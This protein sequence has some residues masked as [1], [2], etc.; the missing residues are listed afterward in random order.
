MVL[1]D[2]SNTLASLPKVLSDALSVQAEVDIAIA[3]SKDIAMHI[4]GD[5][6]HFLASQPEAIR[7]GMKL[8]CMS[9][10]YGSNCKSTEVHPFKTANKNA[11]YFL[12]LLFSPVDSHRGCTMNIGF[13]PCGTH[14]RAT[15]MNHDKAVQAYYSEDLFNTNTVDLSARDLAVCARYLLQGFFDICQ[16]AI[17][18]WGKSWGHASS[19]RASTTEAQV[20]Q[21]FLDGF[22]FSDIY[23]VRRR[24]LLNSRTPHL[25]KVSK[26]REPFDKNKSKRQCDEENWVATPP[27]SPPA[28]AVFDIGDDVKV[29]SS[30]QK[31]MVI[32]V[33][34]DNTYDLE[35]YD[36]G[37]PVCS[38]HASLLDAD[39]DVTIHN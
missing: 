17:N 36:P 9:G 15:L 2:G 5:F 32:R 16:V 27:P 23:C 18:H 28:F 20:D 1:A 33:L 38:M 11:Y 34:G 12:Y 37:V 39:S 6:A 7:K 26:R 25:Q 13:I 3:L 21:E 22:T 4:K 19:S 31:A 10:A 8:R 30:R 35:F 14:F 24:T 29:K